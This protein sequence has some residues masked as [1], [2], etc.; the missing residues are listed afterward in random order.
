MLTRAFV[1]RGADV[2]TAGRQALLVID[3]QV[4]AQASVLAFSRIYLLS[5]LLLVVS[6]PLLLLWRTGRARGSGGS[7]PH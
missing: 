3:R 2:A 6:L 1:A 7:I 5:G 4:Q